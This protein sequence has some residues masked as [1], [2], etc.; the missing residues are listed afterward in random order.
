MGKH[1]ERFMVCWSF[2]KLC[3]HS[4]E[5][6]SEKEWAKGVSGMNHTGVMR[7]RS[8]AE[9]TLTNWVD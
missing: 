6:S 3:R 4:R 1:D 2:A 9:I 7:K 5:N 8:A